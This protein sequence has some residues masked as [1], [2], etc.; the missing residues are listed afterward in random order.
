MFKNWNSHKWARLMLFATLVVL[1][2]SVSPVQ[3]QGETTPPDS[4]PASVGLVDV[5]FLIAAV[6][7]L[8]ARFKMSGDAAFYTA[9]GTGLVLALI[10]QLS[11]HVPTIAPWLETLVNFVKLVVYGMGGYDALVDIGSKIAKATPAT[12]INNA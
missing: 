1:M 8:K 9:L 7:F 5:A 12:V 3:A 11:V 10:P 6:A 4:T 2:I